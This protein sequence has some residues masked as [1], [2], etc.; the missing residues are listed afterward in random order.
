M[1]KLSEEWLYKS[2]EDFQRMVIHRGGEDHTHNSNM[3]N[4]KAYLTDV[5]F[6]LFVVEGIFWGLWAYG[7]LSS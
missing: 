1:G 4:S 3:V 6:G 5:A 7:I 2:K